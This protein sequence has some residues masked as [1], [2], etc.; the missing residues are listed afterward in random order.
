MKKIK[1][2][3]KNKLRGLSASARL[4]GGINLADF[5]KRYRK[6]KQRQKNLSKKEKSMS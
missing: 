4:V 1:L 6:P 3:G 2:M 5:R